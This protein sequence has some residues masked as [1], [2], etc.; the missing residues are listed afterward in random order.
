MAKSPMHNVLHHIRS[1]VVAQEAA[2]L[3][4]SVLLERF[5]TQRDE[6]AFE[7][8]VRRYGPMVMGVCR[9]VLRN[10]E[11]AEDAFQATFLVLVRKAGSI[12][13]RELLGNWLYGVAYHTARAAR[14]AASLRRAKEAKAV[15]RQQAPEESD[16]Q[17]LLPLL[18][19]E[20][21]RLPDKYRIPVILCELQGMSRQDA[22]R[23]LGL[24][25]GT[26]SSRLARARTMLARR[27][28]QRGATLTGGALAMGLGQQAT[29]A[30]VP[31]SLI[32]STV[33][34]GT[35]VLAGSSAAAGVVSTHVAALSEGVVKTMFLSKLKIA[36]AALLLGS[37][38]ALGT[39]E[40]T[41]QVW[42][43]RNAQAAQER[44]E[45]ES[46]ASGAPDSERGNGQNSSGKT[47]ADSR[48]KALLQQ[49]LV[50]AG[51]ITDPIARIGTL[52][53]IASIQS[54]MG[55]KAEA[56]KA[57]QQAL[58]IA[59]TLADGRPKTTV[60]D[61]VAY[62]QSEGGDRSAALETLRQAEQ[63][64][65]AIQEAQAKGN[66]LIDVVLTRLRLED[67]NGALRTAATM[68]DF[69]LS[70]LRDIAQR[71]RKESGQM[72][73]QTLRQALKMA[74]SSDSLTDKRNT[75]IAI[76]AAQ[77]RIGDLEAAIAT[78][79]TLGSDWKVLA[80][81]AIGIAQA[82][83]G[84]VAGALR[85]AS[86]LDRDQSGANVLPRANVLQA[87]A[88]AQ[89][90]AGDRA[91]ARTTL[92]KVRQLADNLPPQHL[93]PPQ[94]LRPVVR[95]TNATILRQ[96]IALTQAQLGDIEGALQTASGL[97]SPREKAKAFLE[98]GMAQREAGKLADARETLY[99]AAAAAEDS[100]PATGTNPLT[101]RPWPAES[102][103]GT[104][105][106]LIAEQ[107]AKARDIKQA[108]RTVQNMPPNRHARQVAL[109][110]I[111]QAQAQTRDVK[112]GLETLALIQEDELKAFVLE[113]VVQAQM[114]EGNERGARAL[115]V[116]QTSPLLKA[117]A[118]LAI[119]SANAK[120]K[121]TKE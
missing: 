7:A 105:M 91:A 55:Q 40:A 4:D 47:S 23:Q 58:Q 75:V 34:A 42:A 71:V 15:A 26:L 3:A 68:K 17:D 53:R 78:A 39:G 79:D 66:A 11:D 13:K 86:T 73:R 121:P 56:R 90:K 9:R 102:V 63:A 28:T 10:P 112:G 44:T 89:E 109:A 113:D 16:W 25:E 84:D 120:Q 29:S 51:N 5:L 67:Y 46:Q 117:H 50:E 36:T 35:S 20:L 37:V 62:A 80:L 2:G 96:G 107:Q 21:S 115:A 81:E 83:A 57:R 74:E 43:A 1:L 85:T 101:G 72:G 94:T 97:D 108:L 6:A 70:T 65:T 33:K 110:R 8:L 95:V 54:K 111:V 60:L 98:I 77:A 82:K 14:S 103:R 45:K 48:T 106:R 27:L 118:L 30:A 38:F 116:R 24:P 76:A 12:A 93:P 87:V 19:Q 114:K 49:A 99:R 18:D 100:A 59:M 64:A 92:Q 119:A 88:V 52:L 31:P 69:Q 22:A 41:R 104:T 32:L 61:Q